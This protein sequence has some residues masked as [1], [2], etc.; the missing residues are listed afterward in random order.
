MF[1]SLV[2]YKKSGK[3]SKPTRVNETETGECAVVFDPICPVL[4]SCESVSV[5]KDFKFLEFIRFRSLEARRGRNYD[6]K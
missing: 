4:S 6:C 2:D 1:V 5:N 3:S